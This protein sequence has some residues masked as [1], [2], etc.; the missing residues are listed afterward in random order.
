MAVPTLTRFGSDLYDAVAP[1]AY[2]DA[3][4]GYA[5][6]YFCDAIGRMIQP[7]DDLAGDTPAGP[8]W[9]QAMDI[10][11]AP[12]DGLAWLAQFVG[13]S[14]LAGLS[15]TAQRDRIRSTDG[16]KRGSIGAFIGAARQHLTGAQSVI[17][18]ERD[19]AACP[20]EPA[21]GVTVITFTAETPDPA[22]TL[23][24]LLA[25]KPAGLVLNYQVEDGQ[26][27]QQLATDYVTFGDVRTAYSTFDL[28]RTDTPDSP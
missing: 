28:V 26:D 14:L 20:S 15:D 27:F 25:Q 5:L 23:A 13:V 17:I 22:Q 19:A 6:A 8:G 2:D 9:S 3:N 1:L 4:Q 11:R 16:M 7:V 21:Y 18:R 10:D 12:A 24:D